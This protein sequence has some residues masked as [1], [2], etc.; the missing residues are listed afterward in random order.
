MQRHAV[1]R[2]RHAMLAN[3]V[4]DI[5]AREI[6][7]RD[8]GDVLGLGIVGR[9]QV[10]RTANGDTQLAIDDVQ[11]LFGEFARA[12]GGLVGAEALL[13][14]NNR[15]AQRGGQ[16]IA[17]GILEILL[18][19]A[20]RKP[21]VPGVMLRLAA[22]ANGAPLV[23]QIIGNDKGLAGPV[24]CLARRR[25][26]LGAGRIAMRLLRAGAGQAKANRRAAGDQHRARCILCRRQSAGDIIGVLAIATVGDPARR[27]EA[28]H[29]IGRSGQRG[30]AVN[31][32]VV[33]VPQ[34]DQA[35]GLQMPGQRNRFVGNAFFQIAVRG[36][37][38]G[39]VIDQLAAIARVQMPLRNRHAHGIGDA[40]AQ[41]PGGGF[42]AR[43]MAIFGMACAG[44]AD[45]AEILDV[46]QGDAWIPG[47]PK[48]RIEQHR[49][50]A[51]RQHKA[52]AVG[53]V[54]VAGIE[55]QE[56][57]EQHGGGIGHAQRQARMTRFCRLHRVH[58][59]GADD[60]GKFADFGLFQRCGGA[61]HKVNSRV[62]RRP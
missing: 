32:D 50:M 61:C 31:G 24:E 21:G 18:L 12:R 7:R 29:F 2:R 15:R 41:R 54:G 51:R 62:G 11:R 39:L 48:Q 57:A 60:I 58:R 26:R 23:Q 9:R 14:G 5:A 16:H 34:H 3:A 45:F 44:A 46:I 28:R 25:N 55:F 1:H 36:D 30:G 10:R 53:P 43:Q 35:L 19:A 49:A 33:V 22:R 27:L 38:I 4:M 52:V 17:D 6:L 20:G 8:G 37:D 59:K 40:L 56:L 13:Q 42:D 47:Q